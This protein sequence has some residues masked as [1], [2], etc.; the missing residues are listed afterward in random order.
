[1]DTDFH[2]ELLVSL[3]YDI[4]CVLCFLLCV[5]L[6]Y[7]TALLPVGVVKDDDILKAVSLD[8]FS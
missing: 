7:I 2:S 1:M 3:R 5:F 6:L 4:L 8:V